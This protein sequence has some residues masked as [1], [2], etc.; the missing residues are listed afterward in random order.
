MTTS[1]DGRPEQLSDHEL[2]MWNVEKDPWLNPNGASVTL[3]DR[4]I[5]PDRFRRYV[6]YAIT[7]IP[8]LHQKVAPAP[9]PLSK[10]I[11]EPDADFD[12]RNHVTEVE[13]P[14]PGT[15]RQ[16]FDLVAELYCEPLDRSR[17]LW[18][19]VLIRGLE[20]GGGALYALAH[21][22]VADGM[23]QLRMAQ[24][25][26]Q[27][28]PDERAPDDVDLD[29]FIAAKV[30]EFRATKG[31][32]NVASV[33]GGLGRRVLD[34]MNAL[35]TDP[36]RAVGKAEE[37]GAAVQS[38]TDL[39]TGRGNEVSGGSPL[40]KNRSAERRLEHVAVPLPG[41][42]AA[43]KSL[44]G[45]VNDVFIVGLTEAAVRYHAERETTVEAF[46]TSF[47]VS[48]RPADGPEDDLAGNAFTPVPVQVSGRAMSFQDRLSEVQT[49]TTEARA[50][51][52]QSGGISGLS[53]AINL[54]PTQVVTSLGRKQAAN[55]DFAT[56]NLRGVPLTLYCAGS[57]VEAT[58]CMGPLAGT[59]ANVTA[60][61]YDGVFHIGL[62]LDPKAIES[63]EDYRRHVD[64]SFADLIAEVGPGGHF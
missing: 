29:A 52:E 55:V 46:N 8:R 28:T 9:N 48:T 49:A 64:E 2:L 22:V 58:I 62:F 31:D 39:L 10:P 19:F 40:W 45:S 11:W 14:A 7:Q 51:S 4:P 36:S 21:H 32:E 59:A 41:L 13:L 1:A 16:L 20:G 23:A 25:Y 12:Y 6:R 50:K 3:V 33:L 5:D 63:G 38:A 24:Y 57:T 54:L 27:L 42:I 26:Q 35:A 56:S 37:L 47:V 15:R 43:A 34:E 53:A 60:L 44:G 17:P 61:S 18:R 30:A